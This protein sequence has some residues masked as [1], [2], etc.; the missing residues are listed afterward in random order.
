MALT[1]TPKAGGIDL[2]PG[3]YEVVC[4]EV[5]TDVIENPQFGNGD[6]IKFKLKVVDMVDEAGDDV[7]LSCMANDVLTPKSKLWGWLQGFGLKV[8]IG[9]PVDVESALGKGAFAVVSQQPG[10]DGGLFTKVEEIIAM[11]K[12]QQRAVRA[13]NPEALT[14]AEWW[15][16]ARDDEG[17]SREEIVEKSMALFEREPPELT[18]EERAD[19]LKSLKANA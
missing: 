13:A 14:T 6:V 4:T 7:E 2:E 19:L 3:T 5:K 16:L 8:E 10:K 15:K 18:A 9:K 12:S 11:P 17:F 1:R